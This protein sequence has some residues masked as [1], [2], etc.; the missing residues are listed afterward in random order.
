MLLLSAWPLA[1]VRQLRQARRRR[2]FAASATATS[3]RAMLGCWSCCS[4]FSRL[5]GWKA[6]RGAMSGVKFEHTGLRGRRPRGATDGASRRTGSDVT[7]LPLSTR[8]IFSDWHGVLSHD[9]FWVTI[10]RSARHPLH[11]QL[12]TGLAGVFA[13]DKETANEWM[14]GLLSSE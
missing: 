3:R 8:V 14:K 12:Q 6:L 9:P 13:S 5:A 2:S 11:H 7:Q 1:C 4:L 10:Q